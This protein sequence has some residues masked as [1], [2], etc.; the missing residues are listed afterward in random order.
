MKYGIKIWAIIGGI[1]VLA[2]WIVCFVGMALGGSRVVS[3]GPDGL[4]LGTQQR[5][6]YESE[7]IDSIK[8]VDIDIINM[9]VK[10]VPSQDEYFWVKCDAD[11]GM[12]SGIT[13][14][15][16]GYGEPQISCVDGVL[17]VTQSGR[18]RFFSFSLFGWFSGENVLTIYVPEGNSFEQIKVQSSN[19]AISFEQE[20]HAE[21]IDLHT[22]NGAVKMEN[23]NCSK[24]CKVK[25]S[26][27][28]IDCFGTFQ[29]SVSLQSSNGV[30][31]IGGTFQDSVSLQSSNGA[32]HIDG[33]YAKGIEAKT[34]NGSISAE[35]DD[36]R[37]NYDIDLDT[38]NGSIT[39]DGVR[40][41]D[42]WREYNSQ[43]RQLRL[44]T[45]NGSI[46]VRFAGVE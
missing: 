12:E 31:H 23:M 46:K 18:T 10:F 26:N 42:E 24:L 33:I 40:V 43:E 35:I 32:L 3:I 27:G 21:N 28:R 29:G 39:V 41:H 7:A 1:L 20:I 2:G 5:Y 11:K 25:T 9:Q 19:S 30:L 44:K 16:G 13:I 15:S 22:S 17:H 45:S 14:F 37:K 8:K 6:H 34:S 36:L 4:K 38:S